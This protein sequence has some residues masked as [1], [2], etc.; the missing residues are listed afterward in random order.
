M[1][2]ALLLL[3]GCW[4]YS[5]L[6][7][8]ATARYLRGRSS[9]PLETQAGI[10]ILK[11]LAGLDEGLEENLRSYFEQDYLQLELIFAMRDSADP[12]AEVLSRLQKEYPMIDSRLL[13]TGEPPY[14][15]DK[16]FKL[17]Q[18]LDVARHELVAMA[19]SDVRVTPDFCRQVAAEF[20]DRN[21][22]LATCPYR[23]IAGRGLWSR[24]EALSMNTDFHSGL[25]TAAMLEGGP[26]FAVG[27]T[28]VARKRTMTS[29]GGME[30][31][32]DYL[33]SEDFMLGRTAAE[34]GFGV[35]LS[36]YVIEHRI[37]SQAMRP[38]FSHRLRWARTTR[39]SRPWGYIGQFF[40]YPAAAAI[41]I[42]FAWPYWKILLPVTAILRIVSAWLVSKK[43]LGAPVRW[44]LLPLQDLLTF[45]FWIAGFFGNTVHWR[46]RR[47][48]LKRDG[49]L[50]P[51]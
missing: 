28:I 50:V 34:A 17:Q 1:I 22:D 6:A 33:S 14:P 29:L 41:C 24:L 7:I 10:S 35:Q 38:N 21:L 39:R 46:G 43:T 11:P 13:L 3:A 19:D 20:Q 45:G 42:C 30:R 4:V 48:I 37:G 47:Y 32:R 5:A 44:L 36:G 49:T 40:T 9:R 25:F 26:K 27:P 16:V 23:A 31:F 51:S 18:M 2:A 15:H 8:I 12:A